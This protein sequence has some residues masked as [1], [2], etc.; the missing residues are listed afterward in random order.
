MKFLVDTMLGKLARYLRMGG[1]DAAYALDRGL[2]DDD[3]V[4]TLAR[5]ENRVV[6]T[7]DRSLAATADDCVLVE[8]T[9]IEDQLRELQA[10]GIEFVL[11]KPTRCGRCNAPLT[12][13]QSGSTPAYAPSLNEMP[14]WECVDC[15]QCFWRGSHWDDVSARLESL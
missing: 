6:L 3:A 14:V 2:E 4:L 13:I 11:D 8:S 9:E 12:R 7:R 1:H 10:A 15:G 5:E